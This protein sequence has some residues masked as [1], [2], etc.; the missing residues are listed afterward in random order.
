[1]DGRGVEEGALFVRDETGADIVELSVRCAYHHACCMHKY[2]E[3][4][5]HACMHARTHVCTHT[6]TYTR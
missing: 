3:I 6:Y 1:M 2:R 4:Q 5:M